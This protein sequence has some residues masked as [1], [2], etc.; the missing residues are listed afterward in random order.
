[1]QNSC[2]LSMHLQVY[3]EC[4]LKAVEVIFVSWAGFEGLG[5][6]DCSVG[7]GGGGGC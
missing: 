1:M 5:R 3:S 4:F 2:L 6:L 7:V